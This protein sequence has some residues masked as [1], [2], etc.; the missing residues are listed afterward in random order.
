[1]NFIQLHDKT[2]SKSVTTIEELKEFLN[3][4]GGTESDVTK[5]SRLFHKGVDTMYWC[6]NPYAMEIHETMSIFWNRDIK[7]LSDWYYN[8]SQEI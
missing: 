1:M 6:Y 2:K 8:S 7:I 4:R 5:L 3:K